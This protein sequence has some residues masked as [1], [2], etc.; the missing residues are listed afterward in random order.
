MSGTFVFIK[1][2][3]E[4]SKQ[5]CQTKTSCG[6][7]QAFDTAVTQPRQRHTQAY[8]DDDGFLIKISLTFA[9]WLFIGDDNEY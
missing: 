5:I 3:H 2:I 9:T 7:I 1:S 8:L 6:S 4:Y